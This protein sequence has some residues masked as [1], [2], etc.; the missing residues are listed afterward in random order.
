MKKILSL[1]IALSLVMGLMLVSCKKESAESLVRD[2]VEKYKTHSTLQDETKSE[3]VISAN[4]VELEMTIENKATSKNN[5]SDDFMMHLVTTTT[6]M[7]E[8]NVSEG[9]YT[10]GY[11][12]YVENGV[13][14]K[15][16]YSPNTGVSLMSLVADLPSEAYEGVDIIKNKDGSKTVEFSLSSEQLGEMH[17]VMAER[18]NDIMGLEESY[19]IKVTDTVA[20]IT[21]AKGEIS[22]LEL[23]YNTYATI[24][25]TEVSMRSNMEGNIIS[26]SD[27]ITVTM[28]EG[29]LDF[30]EV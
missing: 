13:G 5:G 26:F 21:V 18:F 1:I 14:I 28:P 29:Y 8:K 10:N 17:T 16:A 7:G 2:A 12:Y 4:G 3:M 9:F 24:D 15:T 25:G 30:P 22:K 19:D 27:D 23:S 6:V 11:I 20:R